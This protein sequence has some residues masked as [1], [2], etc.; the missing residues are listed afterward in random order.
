RCPSLSD[1]PVFRRP[2]C[3]LSEF[4]IRHPLR[5]REQ[6]TERTKQVRH[7]MPRYFWRRRTERLCERIEILAPAQW[8]VIDDVV[9][10]RPDLQRRDYR[11]RRIAMGDRWEERLRTPVSASRVASS[12]AFQTGK[13]LTKSGS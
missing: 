11:G 3:L 4:P 2:A 1:A 8:L 5:A 6:T 7:P 10:S 13:L 9:G 12:I